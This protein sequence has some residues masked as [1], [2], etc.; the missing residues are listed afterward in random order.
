MAF[1]F[2]K[3]AS[4]KMVRKSQPTKKKDFNDAK[5]DSLTKAFDKQIENY[6]KGLLTDKNGNPKPSNWMR[7]DEA[8]NEFISWR[9]SNKPV[10][11]APEFA[12]EAKGWMYS[13]DVVNDLNSLREDIEAGKF[14]KQLKE[15][16]TRTKP[17]KEKADA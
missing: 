8:G 5:R 2:K 14:D 13:D 9:I 1:D 16:Y 15:A 10:Y 3:A 4:V 17:P 12:G 6:Q 7:K 11:F